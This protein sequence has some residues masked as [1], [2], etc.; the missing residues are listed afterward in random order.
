MQLPSRVVELYLVIPKVEERLTLINELIALQGWRTAF[1]ISANPDNMKNEW[2]LANL[3][4]L[5]LL[6]VYM[7]WPGL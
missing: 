3:L 7:I 6:V 1:S 4:G 2:L 5:G